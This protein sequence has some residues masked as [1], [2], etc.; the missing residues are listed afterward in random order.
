[1]VGVVCVVATGTAQ[2]SGVHW[3][4][5]GNGYYTS[6]STGIVRHDLPAMTRTLAVPREWLTPPGS[7]KPL[8]VRNFSFSADGNRVLIYTNSKRV[9]RYDTRGD[10]WVLTLTSRRLRKL[11]ENL[12]AS[13]LMF[14]KFSPQ[15]NRIAYVC[16]RNIFVEE[17]ESGK[18]YQLTQTDGSKKLINGT[19][20]WVYEEELDCRDGFRWSP[21]GTRIAYWQVDA[22][23]VRDFYLINNTDSIYSRII[24]IEYP[25]VGETPSPVKI[26]VVDVATGATTWLNIPGDPRQQ[27]IP[28]MEWTTSSTEVIFQM[29]N[30]KQNATTL[31]LGDVRSG[32]CTPIYTESDSA[33]IDTKSNWNGGETT[34]WDWIAGGKEFLWGS[35]KDGWRHLYRIARDGKTERLIT[36]GSFDMITLVHYDES[37]NVVYFIA[38]PEN[39]TRRALY[40]VTMDGTGKAERVSPG[41]EEGTHSYDISPNGKFAQHT[42]SNYYT[43]TA[44]EWISLPDH[45]PLSEDESVARKISAEAK[46]NSTIEFFKVTTEDGVEV[47]A[48]M[49]KPKD[50]DPRKKYPVVILVYSEPGS[51]TVQ[52]RYGLTRLYHYDGDL[53]ADGYIYMS[54]DNRGTPAPKGRAWRKSIYRKIGIINIR[55]QAMAL[56][57]VCE[58]PFIDTS[59]IAVWGHSGGGTATLNLLFQY[60]ELYKTGIALAAVVNQ[61]A[62]DNIYQERFMGLPQENREDFVNGSPLAYAKNLRGHL[63]YIHGTGDDNV[64]Y[65]NAELL[66]NEL[67]KYNKQF[68][69]MPYPNRTHGIMEGEG[70]RKHL[71]T[72]FTTFLR[73]YCP[74]GGR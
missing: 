36:R 3:T 27:Y 29:L 10:Y 69:F 28:R 32:K 42:F 64:H 67:V 25:K 56:K 41:G 21:D 33:W 4:K 40:R 30:R 47:D 43:P 74:P 9:W 5:D 49:A 6:D 24:P 12:P 37:S 63:L 58:Q 23:G 2:R 22:N 51:Q 71:S 54:F 50:F 16:E 62:Y 8:A 18:R 44:R 34:S 65:Q 72:L 61:L 48:W 53:A 11:G 73:E 1:M 59:R 15:S 19:F 68:Q 26:G 55:D 60:P 20:D 66:I 31:F 39:A 46:Q 14:A 57:K 17:I 35:E 70:T 45:K 7:D 52:D 38:S 13:S